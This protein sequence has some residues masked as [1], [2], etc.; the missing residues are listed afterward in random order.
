MASAASQAASIPLRCC[1]C[2]KRP[3]F[4]DLS[5]LLTHV[6]SKGHLAQHFK[7]SVRA[8]TDQAA[9]EALDKYNDWFHRYGVETLCANRLRSNE[10][11]K[12]K[13]ARRGFLLGAPSM[14][15]PSRSAPPIAPTETGPA[16]PV[17]ID[18]SYYGGLPPARSGV[19]ETSLLGSGYVMHHGWEP[20]Q[21]QHQHQAP[22][23]RMHLWHTDPDH[24]HYA[25]RP[26]PDGSPTTLSAKSSV[27]GSQLAHLG[28]TTGSL[29]H[30][31]WNH[32]FD[33]LID[34]RNSVSVEGERSDETIDLELEA[35]TQLKGVYWPGMDIFD[36]AP[37]E[38]KRRRNQ[39]KDGSVLAQMELNST[40]VEPTELIFMADGE[41]KKER[42]IYSPIDHTLLE[43]EQPP[44]KKRPSSKAKQALAEAS[45]NVPKRV[46]TS[47]V[48]KSSESSRDP[49]RSH[50]VMPK[51]EYS[52][53]QGSRGPK[54]HR[55]VALS[56]PTVE[57]KGSKRPAGSPVKKSRSGNIL[58]GQ[59]D[60]RHSSSG[61]H[62]DS[63]S[64][65]DNAAPNSSHLYTNIGLGST[66]LTPSHLDGSGPSPSQREITSF[67]KRIDTRPVVSKD[68]VDH[69]NSF[70]HVS[71][72]TLTAG[73]PGERSMEE[74]LAA[75]DPYATHLFDTHPIDF[76]TLA[77]P[78]S[79]G[80]SH[81]PLTMNHQ[82]VHGY[83]S[84]LLTRGLPGMPPHLYGGGSNSGGPPEMRTSSSSASSS[85]SQAF[86]FRREAGPTTAG[87]HDPFFPR[88]R[89]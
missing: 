12:A 64:S 77:S 2:P 35:A 49:I 76:G 71:P 79:L 7:T 59:S 82:F 34:S 8:S 56:A 87:H 40:L 80:Y 51:K 19:D 54:I 52:S 69:N 41:F 84:P 20:S 14:A 23:P 11:K 25:P 78:T 45:T 42:R 26:I 3:K 4:S 65:V 75:S 62:R 31:N 83:Q 70:Y 86:S 6:A 81:H 74:L 9:R 39:K 61:S 16:L 15:A 30:A 32:S 46:A 85:A 5:H 44:P 48:F 37:P 13:T 57:K 89:G 24:L 53:S 72:S 29:Q 36:S 67:F 50:E 18:D 55:P 33:T 21:H 73:Y 66:Y 68:E 10:Q 17:N 58:D 47:M 63:S 88:M 28:E 60:K 22:V 1:I 43:G 27:S 38:M